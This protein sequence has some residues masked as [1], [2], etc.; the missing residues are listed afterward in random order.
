MLVD[1]E[2]FFLSGNLGVG[3]PTGSVARG[4]GRGETTLSPSV[5]TWLDLGN[6]VALHG[7]FGTEVGLQTGDAELIYGLALTRSFHGPVLFPNFKNRNDDHEH[8]HAFPAGFTS[9]ILEMTGSS[10]LNGNESGQTFFEL[11]PGIS[12]TPVEHVEL[13]F[14]VRFPLFYPERL[15]TQYIFTVGRSF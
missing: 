4:L 12:H 15:D 9:L 13:R 3:I 5:T 14:G 1:G 10:G 11:L 8:E 7:Q 2:T 6:W